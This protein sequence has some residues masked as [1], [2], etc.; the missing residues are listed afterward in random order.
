MIPCLLD[1]S[2]SRGFVLFSFVFPGLCTMPGTYHVVKFVA[3]QILEGL[4]GAG[5]REM[6]SSHPGI[7]ETV[8]WVF[9]ELPSSFCSR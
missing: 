5:E 7:T 1:L 2:E 3:L 4:G 8:L 6:G 9:M